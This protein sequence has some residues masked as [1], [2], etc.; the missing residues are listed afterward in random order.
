MTEQ[1]GLW[2]CKMSIIKKNVYNKNE[3]LLKGKYSSAE[4]YRNTIPVEIEGEW[5][6]EEHS[7]V[8]KKI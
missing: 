5:L 2:I 6:P 7:R 8:K 1:D 4:S 3:D